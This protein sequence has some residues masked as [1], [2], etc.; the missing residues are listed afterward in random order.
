[1]PVTVSVATGFEMFGLLNPVDGDQTYVPAPLAVSVVELPAQMVVLG[2]PVMVIV[3]VG[4]TVTVFVAV[5]V[6]PILSVIVTEKPVVA[7]RLND[8]GVEEE[9]FK[10]GGQ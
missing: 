2:F 1:M 10:G 3:G 5:A 8:V 9:V 7:L 6:H 4:F